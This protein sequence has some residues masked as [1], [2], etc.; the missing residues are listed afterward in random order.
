ML[1]HSTL[2]LLINQEKGAIHYQ[3]LY[4]IYR[5]ERL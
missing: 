5:F 4:H 3:E 2:S 1:A